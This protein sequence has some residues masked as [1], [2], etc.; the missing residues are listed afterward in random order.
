MST[1]SST[2]TAAFVDAIVARDF[3]A[4]RGLLHPEID[5]RAMTPRRIWEADGPADVEEVLRTWLADPDEDIAAVE[6]VAGATVE[7]TERAG[8]RV[9]GSGPDGAFVFEQQAFMRERDG[10]VGWLRIMCSGSR[11][12]GAAY[13]Q[14][15]RRSCVASAARSSSALMSARRTGV[16]IDQCPPAGQRCR[17]HQPSRKAFSEA[18]GTQ[19]VVNRCPRRHRTTTFPAGGYPRS[20][21]TDTS[22]SSVRATTASPARRRDRDDQDMRPS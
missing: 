18:P 6:P 9:R 8:W 10:Q 3:A 5:F 13:A 15:I 21:S 4:A 22:A 20:R 12:V 17:R 14:G 1:T 19:I 7:D 11:P 2:V 16:T